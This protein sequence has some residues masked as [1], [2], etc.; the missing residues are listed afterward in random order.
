MNANAPSYLVV[1]KEDCPTCALVEEVLVDLQ[2]R[3]A[4]LEVWSQDNPA[5]PR[6]IDEVGD[7]REL[8]KWQAEAQ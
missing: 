3:G 6:S 4:S 5:F 7:D 1:V 2:Q 8:E